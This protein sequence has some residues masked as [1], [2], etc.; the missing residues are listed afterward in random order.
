MLLSFAYSVRVCVL[1]MVTGA[2]SVVVGGGGGLELGRFTLALAVPPTFLL[3]VT[4]ET[5]VGGEQLDTAAN[6][7]R[8]MDHNQN[9]V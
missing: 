2:A 5:R 8:L 4:A 1:G 9:K 6:T 3:R 7:K